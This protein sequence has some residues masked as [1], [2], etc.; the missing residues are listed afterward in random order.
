MGNGNGHVS[1]DDMVD[2]L[3]AGQHRLQ[4]TETDHASFEGIPVE[5]PSRVA[6]EKTWFIRVPWRLFT[7]LAPLP[8]K[9]LAVYMLAWREGHMHASST[10]RLTSMSLRLCGITRDE[11]ALALACLEEQGLITVTRQRGKNPLITVLALV[12]RFGQK[13]RSA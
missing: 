3:V 9:T 7:V 12:G 10:V 5:L 4:S 8:G 1:F 6:Q 11:K 2:A 13:P